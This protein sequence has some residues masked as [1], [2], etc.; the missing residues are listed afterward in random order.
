MLGAYKLSFLVLTSKKLIFRRDNEAS[1]A[2][3]SVEYDVEEI[4]GMER[5]G[6]WRLSRLRFYMVGE[7]L[8][9]IE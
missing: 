5:H 3:D 7:R 4:G 9:I 8:S 2:D 6:I 1:N